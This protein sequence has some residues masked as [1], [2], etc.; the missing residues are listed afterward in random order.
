MNNVLKWKPSFFN[1]TL[2]RDGKCV[3]FNSV[4]AQMIELAEGQWE[5]LEDCFSQTAQTGRCANENMLRYL[6]A[7][8]FVVPEGED[9]YQR[10]HAKF[11]ATRSSRRKLL[12][13][14]VPTMACNLRCTYCFQQNIPRGKWM[15]PDVQRALVEFV[16]RKAEGSRQLVV[17]WF[18]GEPLLTYDIIISLS[19]EFQRICKEY[20]IAYHSEM[21]TNGTLLTSKIIDSFPRISLRVIQISL[22]GK[23]S[24]Y[25]QRKQVSLGR[26]EAFYGFLVEHAQS[27]V[28]ATGSVTI[29]INVDRDNADEGKEVVW[30]FKK[31]GVNDPRIDFRLGFLN[32]SRG[33]IDCIPHDCFSHAE[34]ANLELDFRRFL[35]NEGYMVYGMPQPKDYPCTAV[36]RNSYTV[37]PDGRI[38]KCVPAIGSEQSVFSQ[39][40]PDDLT[41]TLIETSSRKVPYE[42]LDPFESQ[43][44]RNCRLLP[45]CLGSCP[46]MHEVNG[47]FVCSMKEGLA[48]KLAFSIGFHKARIGD[49]KGAA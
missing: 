34:F 7:L 4:T 14:I 30:L 10:E 43:A 1:V 23:P 11:L 24:T 19:E 9:E 35:A 2:R 27:I 33:I 36:V 31:H 49:G 45:V 42:Q 8:G 6:I 48:D 17:Q 29:R 46:K 5:I 16:R 13:T 41:H 28:D 26:A 40:Y 12:L 47:T 21:L 3:I 39:L 32:T 15:K 38:G 25:A 37:D 18:G 22:D 20:D 44:C